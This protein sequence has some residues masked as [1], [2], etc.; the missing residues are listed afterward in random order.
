MASDA[1]SEAGRRIWT[2][3]HG[4]RATAELAGLLRDA[5][6]ERLIDV[7]RFPGS[8]RNPHLA[9]EALAT[10]LPAAGIAYEWR[11]DLGGRRRLE[12]GNTNTAWRDEA[13]RAYAGYMA[14]D[15]FRSALRDL[16][17]EAETARV[18]IMCSETLWWRCHRRL[19]ADALALDGFEVRHLIDR[20]LGDRHVLHPAARR[21]P[22]GSVTYP[23]AP[24]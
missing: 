15:A 12:A 20:P 13:F 7:R 14:T 5:G 18:A 16:E 3:G 2:I 4:T 19:V 23:G 6:I 24:A 22:D 21:A 1:S 8:R 17:A 11:E 9:R 10:A